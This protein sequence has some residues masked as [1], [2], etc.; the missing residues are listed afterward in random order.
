[1]I[2]GN[3][4]EAAS[5][6]NFRSHIIYFLFHSYHSTLLPVIQS[7]KTVAWYIFFWFS[8]CL[9]WEDNSCGSW[10]FMDE[11]GS[12]LPIFNFKN[13][14]GEVLPILYP[15]ITHEPIEVV[16][17]CEKMTILRDWKIIPQY[18]ME[19]SFQ[20]KGGKCRVKMENKHLL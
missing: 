1:M 20:K 3:C 9:Q 8:S 11:S 15:V 18:K 5:W 16:K 19:R 2:A 7:L 10:C 6:G 13:L 12:L 4:L 14:R 17:T